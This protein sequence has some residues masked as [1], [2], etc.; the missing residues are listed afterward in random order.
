[1]CDRIQE[2]ISDLGS[3]LMKAKLF[4]AVSIFRKLTVEFSFA[5][6]EIK[7]KGYNGIDASGTA[8]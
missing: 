2:N 1:M 4:I 7:L 3:H 8:Y 5:G 6:A